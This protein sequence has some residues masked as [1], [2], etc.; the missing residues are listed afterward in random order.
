MPLEDLPLK[1]GNAEWVAVAGLFDPLT[2]VQASRL[3][4]LS[5]RGKRLLAIVEPGTASL[6]PAEARAA[7]VAALRK[8]ELVTVAEPLAWRELLA[9]HHPQIEIVEDREGER[10]RSV[11]F[12]QLIV[13]RQEAQ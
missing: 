7:L 13:R 2:H 10:N 9:S 5:G 12:V 3:A 6:L 1:L 4:E 8:V 11:E